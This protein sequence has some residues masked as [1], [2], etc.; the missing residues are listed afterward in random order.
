MQ[1]KVIQSHMSTEGSILCT[2][3]VSAKNEFVNTETQN[4]AAYYTYA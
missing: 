4:N 3:T 2:S 1:L